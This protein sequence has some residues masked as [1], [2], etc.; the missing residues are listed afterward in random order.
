MAALRADFFHDSTLDV[1][2]NGTDVS[3]LGD[4]HVR[5]PRRY[6]MTA[7][8][9]S[10]GTGANQP[11]S[12]GAP[13]YGGYGSIQFT[14]A[15]L[16]R[17]FR[18]TTLFLQTNDATLF[19]VQKSG[20]AGQS[21]MGNIN[22]FSSGLDLEYGGAAFIDARPF[23]AGD[24]NF[25]LLDTTKI[26]AVVVRTRFNRIPDMSVDGSVFAVAGAPAART[27]AVSGAAPLTL[28][29]ASGANQCMTMDWTFGGGFSY[30][31]PANYGYLIARA[32]LRRY[33]R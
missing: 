18:A 16:D 8:D 5:W 25:S 26:Q 17:L 1:T 14:A 2:L 23:P 32:A 4:Q 21:I 28:G 30:E 31:L 9:L 11:L 15:N 22:A 10:Q 7:W 24:N 33:G 12:T 13:A 27:T 3:G 6:N 20:G 29:S 19:T